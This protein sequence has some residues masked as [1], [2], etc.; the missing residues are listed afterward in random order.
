MQPPNDVTAT[1]KRGPRGP[2]GQQGWSGNGPQGTDHWDQAM[3]AG[4]PQS[5]GQRRE[6]CPAQKHRDCPHIVLPAPGA[7]PGPARR[8]LRQVWDPVGTPSVPTPCCGEPVGGSHW[9]ELRLES[10]VSDW[11][12]RGGKAL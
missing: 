10:G 7:P 5:P 2:R 12:Q 9:G 1:E 3:P 6:G 8:G 4:D 11:G